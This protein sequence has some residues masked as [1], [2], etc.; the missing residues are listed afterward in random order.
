MWSLLI[1]FLHILQSQRTVSGHGVNFVNFG[2]L[3]GQGV[4]D[5]G[6]GEIGG[7]EKTIL[8]RRS[9]MNM[10]LDEE[11]DKKDGE[12]CKAKHA[13][14][15]NKDVTKSDDV[16]SKNNQANATPSGSEKPES[17]PEI[18]T[19]E[20]TAPQ[21]TTDGNDVGDDRFD[22]AEEEGVGKGGSV[23]GE[24]GH[25]EYTRVRLPSRDHLKLGKSVDVVLPGDIDTTVT[26]LSTNPLVVEVSQFTVVYIKIDKI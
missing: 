18:T 8:Q 15:T 11:N 2:A 4:G 24:G 12:S 17:G 9:I 21:T 22:Y 23:K 3:L 26:V 1:V 7:D 5:G 6:Q 19:S 10:F 14:K 16:I 25:G 13:V 20:R